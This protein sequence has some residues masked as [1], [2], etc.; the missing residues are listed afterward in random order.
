VSGPALRKR[1]TSAVGYK[2]QT[3]DA[4]ADAVIGGVDDGESDTGEVEVDRAPPAPE[5]PAPEQPTR[6][7]K[8]K[9]IVPTRGETRSA[10]LRNVAMF[11][12]TIASACLVFLYETVGISYPPIGKTQ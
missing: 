3:G 6:T 11:G 12:L 4:G 8:A 10:Y 2:A 7:S 1:T 9:A 5:D